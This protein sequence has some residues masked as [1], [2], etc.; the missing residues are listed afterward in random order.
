M[1]MCTKLVEMSEASNAL[2]NR[3]IEP[4]LMKNGDFINEHGSGT[5]RDNKELG[6]VWSLQCLSE[7][8]AYT[9]GYGF[10]AFKAHL[11]MFNDSISECD[12]KAYTLAG[13]WFKA[14]N[15]KKL[16]SEDYFEVKYAAIYDESRVLQWE[17]IVVI[18]RETSANFIPQNTMVLAKVT[19]YQ[20]SKGAWTPP[21]NFA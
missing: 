6:F 9:F 13:R 5:L 10:S 18:V 12:E 14:Y 11:V 7:R 15:A 17:G 2:P 3:I 8:L 1:T 20:S 16:F 19:E 4:R 21:V